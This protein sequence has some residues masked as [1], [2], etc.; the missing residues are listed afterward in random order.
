LITR[1]EREFLD[2]VSAQFDTS[3][4]KSKLITDYAQWILNDLQDRLARAFYAWS[5]IQTTE[6]VNNNTGK[7]ADRMRDLGLEPD[8]A[9]QTAQSIAMLTQGASLYAVQAVIQGVNERRTEIENSLWRLFTYPF[10][11][12]KKLFAANSRPWWKWMFAVMVVIVQAGMT[13]I[14]VRLNSTT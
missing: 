8:Q 13:R 14:Y 1:Y 3:S 2:T 9:Q 5:Q 10:E 6:V 7:L 11:A 4:N 12:V